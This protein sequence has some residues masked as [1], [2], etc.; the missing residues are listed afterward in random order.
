MDI[1]ESIDR[2]LDC[3]DMIFGDAFYEVF[4]ARYPQ[5]Q[6]YFEGVNMQRQSVL[7]TMAMLVIEQYE[8][9]AYPAAS[10]YLKELG[11]KHHEWKIPRDTYPYFRD[12]LLDALR[13]FHGEDW[14]DDLADEWGAAIDLTT[15]QM[16]KGYEVEE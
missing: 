4:L 6:K 5:V 2:I 13:R 1:H 16:M 12:A 11:A 14:D 3:E 8:G 15:I 9:S 10:R 7:L